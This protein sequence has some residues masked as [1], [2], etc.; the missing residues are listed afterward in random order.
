[1]G[2]YG[3]FVFCMCDL[4]G[5]TK[6]A[7]IPFSAWLPAAMA[8]PSPVSSLVHSSTLV[9]AGVYLLI[10]FRG[11]IGGSFIFLLMYFS[12]AT[13]FMAGLGANFECDLKRVIA[14]STLRQVGLIL[15][16]LSLGL[17]VLAFFHLREFRFGILDLLAGFLRSLGLRRGVVC[18]CYSSGSRR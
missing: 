10:R 4:A 2:E 5:I 9:T 17:P 11:L 16:T 15:F 18:I 13:I 7:Q 3:S 8:A 14:L 1:M 6:G 12:C